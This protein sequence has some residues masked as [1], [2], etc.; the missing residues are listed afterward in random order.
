MKANKV[1]DKHLS[2][3]ES[4]LALA[5]AS[6]QKRVT[7][8]VT[9]LETKQGVPVRSAAN[10][11][12]VSAL[13]PELDNALRES[14]YLEA[15]GALQAGDADIIRTLRETSKIPLKFSKAD[16]NLIQALQNMQNTEFQGI[17]FRAMEAVRKTVFDTI[18][19]GV[20]LEKGLPLIEQSLSTNLQRYAWTYANTTRKDVMQQVIDLGVQDYEG[21]VYWEYQGP[22][23]DVTRE[24]C[25]ELLATQFFSDAE[26]E[27]ADADTAEERMYNC[28]HVFAPIP[29]SL[30][31]SK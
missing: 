18:M 23:D 15:V 1:A 13:L 8:L 2:R 17:G 28:R 21:D 9:K 19:N 6:I 31:E 14:G 7:N 27:S 11:A 3:F 22:L 12:A 30:Y 16:A 24:A 20:P 25:I 29:K 4:A 5:I 26:R 10:I